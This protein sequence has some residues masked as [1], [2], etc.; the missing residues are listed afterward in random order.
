MKAT[1]SREEPAGRRGGGLCAQSCARTAGRRS[2]WERCLPRLALTLQHLALGLV[3]LLQKAQAVAQRVSPGSTQAPGCRATPA[4]PPSPRHR[5]MHKII[6]SL[7]TARQGPR[8]PWHRLGF[9]HVSAR[10]WLHSA[11][12]DITSSIG[13]RTLPGA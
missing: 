5:L 3:L 8:G 6:Y 13:C 2:E 1:G 11:H 4:A 7:F 9:E 12:R 10:G